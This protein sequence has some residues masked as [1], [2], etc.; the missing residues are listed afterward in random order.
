M[1]DSFG[2][3]LMTATVGRT[4]FVSRVTLGSLEDLGYAV[5]YDA[6]DPFSLPGAST[7]ASLRAASGDVPPGSST[8]VADDIYRE[9]PR[10][11]DLSVE[12]VEV[13]GSR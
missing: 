3:E 9:P 8:P 11:L 12:L 2:D 4:A 5:N 6:A 1:S 10:A 7:R 13:L